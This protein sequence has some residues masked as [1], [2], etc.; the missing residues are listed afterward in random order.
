MN[1]IDVYSIKLIK[2]PIINGI[3][4][5]HNINNMIQWAKENVITDSRVSYDKEFYNSLYN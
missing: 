3:I 4:G 1:V 5:V 2:I